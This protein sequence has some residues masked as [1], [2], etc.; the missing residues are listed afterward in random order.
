[1]AS[2]S[3]AVPNALLLIWDETVGEP[4][5]ADDGELWF[6]DSCVA[7]GTQ[8]DVDGA[9]VVS[10]E[11]RADGRDSPPRF[12]GVLRT[13]SR[14]LSVSTVNDAVVLELRVSSERTRV[15]IWT[16]A[17]ESPSRVEIVATAERE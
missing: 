2:T 1:M 7:I 17:P 5:D 12:D 11:P 13:P 6:N 15:R 9:T 4:P 3:L 10:L 16:D 8:A 14:K